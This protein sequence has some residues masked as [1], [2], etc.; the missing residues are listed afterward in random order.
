MLH[1][2]S[3]NLI[4]LK[5]IKNCTLQSRLF[6]DCV[7]IK[8]NTIYLNYEREVKNV[9]IIP[10][11]YRVTLT[12]R[13]TIPQIDNI[14]HIWWTTGVTTNYVIQYLNSIVKSVHIKLVLPF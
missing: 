1:T 5:P 2:S 10:G 4:A 13:N 8:I 6:S 12:V 11:V 7:S 14:Y 3:H 9:L